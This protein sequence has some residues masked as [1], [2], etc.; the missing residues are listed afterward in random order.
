MGEEPA[1]G[2]GKQGAAALCYRFYL[3]FKT[4]YMCNFD[5][6]GK[7]QKLNKGH[8]SEEREQSPW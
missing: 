3:V 4:M 5:K 8:Q 1:V 2:G 7:I 6:N